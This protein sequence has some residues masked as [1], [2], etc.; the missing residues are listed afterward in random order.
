[1]ERKE[2]DSIEECGDDNG[3]ERIDWNKEVEVPGEERRRDAT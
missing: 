3:K 1:V 2:G